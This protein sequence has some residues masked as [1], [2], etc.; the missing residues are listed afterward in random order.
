M[1]QI[2]TAVAR[3]LSGE[4]RT[5]IRPATKTPLWSPLDPEAEVYFVNI[6]RRKLT[7][8]ADIF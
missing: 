4:L 8:K 3:Q 6:A 7:N 5:E 1:Q 2:G